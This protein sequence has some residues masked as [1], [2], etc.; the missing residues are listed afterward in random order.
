MAFGMTLGDNLTMAASASMFY[1]AIDY[2]NKTTVFYTADSRCL[3][4][5]C[6]AENF[7]GLDTNLFL[8]NVSTI[9]V[10][11]TIKLILIL[12]SNSFFNFFVK[13]KNEK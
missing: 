8:N 2:K 3:R 5:H 12:L 1:D 11:I 6:A 10:K 7:R 9:L 13:M 4:D